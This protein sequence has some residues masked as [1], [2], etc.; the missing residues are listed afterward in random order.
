MALLALIAL[1]AAGAP[2]G[3]AEA[4]ADD[5]P[6][7]GPAVSAAPDGA[8]MSARFEVTAARLLEVGLYREAHADLVRASALAGDPEAALSL[9][10]RAGEA[11]WEGALWDDARR[12][13]AALG[14]GPEETLAAA[15]S[16]YRGRQLQ[17][18][19]DTLWRTEGP[20]AAY[21]EGWCLLR[22]QQP[23]AAVTAWGRVPAGHA[24]AAPAG[25]LVAEVEGW[26]PLPRRSPALAGLMSAAL[27]GA[28]QAWVGRWA[29]AGSAL[30]VNGLLVASGVELYR[31]E[32]WFGLGAVGLLGVGFYGGN[33]FSAVHGAR[34]FNRLAWEERLAGVPPELELRLAAEG[35]GWR[36]D[37]GL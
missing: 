16:L 4:P 33:V 20:A 15:Y 5:G 21:L 10:L 24:L 36:A 23:E 12:Y 29:E 13:Y 8:V 37:A 25:R 31:R 22:D 34:R 11:L 1:A 28:G 32:Q 19:M 27:P 3:P 17:A 9:S 30:L 35:P 26:A 14:D 6:V 18:S 2:A 7:S